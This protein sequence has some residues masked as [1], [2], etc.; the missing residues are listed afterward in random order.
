MVKGED[1]VAVK[2]GD[3]SVSHL[4]NKG[5]SYDTVYCF[6]SFDRFTGPSLQVFMQV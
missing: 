4:F 3:H 5:M 1:Q 2:N 6:V